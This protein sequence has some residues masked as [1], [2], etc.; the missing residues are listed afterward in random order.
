M[1]FVLPLG[2]REALQ[3]ILG[4]LGVDQDIL[5]FLGLSKV[6]VEFIVLVAR[7]LCVREFWCHLWC[8]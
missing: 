8:F 3:G 2:I 1:L 6:L 5:W 7:S 4:I